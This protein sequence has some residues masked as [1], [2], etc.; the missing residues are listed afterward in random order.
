MKPLLAFLALAPAL[1]FGQADAP[2]ISLDSRGD[3]VREVLATLFAQ[4]NKPYALDAA[5]KGKL[6]VKLDRFPYAKALGVVLSQAGLQ[7]K[8]KD[9]VTMISPIPVPPAPKTAP[10]KPVVAKPLPPKP[11]VGPVPTAV[12]ARRVTTR[13]RRAPLADVL[14][15]LGE[16]AKVE[17]EVDPSVPAYRVDAFFIKTSL[18]YALDRVCKAA[19][20]RYEFSDGKIVVGPERPKG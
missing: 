12:L 9:G 1:A 18:K 4:A 2:R 3:D 19:N 13:A 17:I 14:A 15:S 16:Q 5:I 8:D 10:V 20:L 6:Y 11:A 7:A